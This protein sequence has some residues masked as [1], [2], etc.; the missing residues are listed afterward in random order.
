MIVVGQEHEAL[1]IL[2]PNR[3]P[4]QT[5]AGLHKILPGRMCQFDGNL[6]T[7]VWS[8]WYGGLMCAMK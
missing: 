1:V 2:S 7:R 5:T 3:R 6:E 8:T 4:F